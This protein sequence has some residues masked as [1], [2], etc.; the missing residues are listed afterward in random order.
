MHRRELIHAM[1]AALGA[2]AL[3]AMAPADLWATARRAHA[4]LS[5]DREAASLLVLNAHQNATVVA[6]T[7]HI[8]PDTDTPGAAAARVNEFIDVMLAEWYTPEERDRFLGGLA[9]VDRRAAAAFGA[10][11]VGATVAQQHALLSGMDAE[12]AAL[13]EADA[14]PEQHFFHRLKYLTLYGYYTSE[15]GQTVELREA[16]IPG[17]YDPCAPIGDAHSPGDW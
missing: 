1:S 16:I 10:P 11:F 8:I 14:K 2:S 13:R 3:T 7:D 9:D 6:L 5:S 17:R 4:R 12:V 15:I